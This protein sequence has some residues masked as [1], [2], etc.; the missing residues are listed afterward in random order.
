MWLSTTFPELIELDS[1]TLRQ[2]SVDDAPALVEAINHSREELRPWLPFANVDEAVTE[3]AQR[4]LEQVVDQRTSRSLFPYTIV[5]FDGTFT[6]FI[7]VRPCPEPGRVSIGYWLDPR[8]WGKGLVTSAAL[9]L[10]DTALA[11]PEIEGVEIRCHQANRRSIAV[12]RRLGFTLVETRDHSID[13]PGQIG[14]FM[15]WL[16]KRASS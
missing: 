5:T 1:V 3:A 16:K 9:A 4:R 7:E 2:Q 15:V 11:I 10:S 6:G 14:R 8:F 13:A 12:A